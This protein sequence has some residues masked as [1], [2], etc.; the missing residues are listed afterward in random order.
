MLN[1][2]ILQRLLFQKAPRAASRLNAR[3]LSTS[4]EFS[5]PSPRQRSP[6]E[7]IKDVNMSI[8][9]V[10]VQLATDS[11]AFR[12]LKATPLTACLGAEISG[13][14]LSERLN[15]DVI[16]EI[17]TAYLLFGVIF[18]RN[19]KLTPERQVELAKKLGVID[20]HPIV[21][22]M[23]DYP[24][25]IQIVREAGAAT[26]FGE[27]WHSDNSYM[28]KPSL[29]SILYAVEIPPVGNDTMFSC[30]YALHESLSPKMR[31]LLNELKAVHTAGEAFA[32]SN[33]EG[34]S[35]DNPEAAMKYVKAQELVTN[36]LHPTLRT[37]PETGRKAV[38]VNSMF[39]T[40]F[41][42]MSRAESQPILN[43]I[44]SR[45]GLP[46]LTCRYRWA[47]GDVALWDNRCVQH[48]A[49]GDNSS[50]QRIMRRVTLAGDVPV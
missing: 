7:L 46:E 44:F 4:M 26:S 18:F 29:G 48:V 16:E 41:D 17:W 6:I 2:K 9:D 49:I 40:N 37:H 21:Q 39:T 47:A 3:S 23:E 36:A 20:R 38:F 34:G 25:V 27:T 15:D 10:R 8:K 31:D 33:V 1:S 45:V 30:M 22:G 50:H 11:N 35:F 32:P 19:Q 43:Y 13:I 24:D 5:A 28:T 12:H 14:D 42:G